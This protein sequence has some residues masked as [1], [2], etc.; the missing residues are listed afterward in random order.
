M[1]PSTRVALGGAVLFLFACAPLRDPWGLAVHRGLP[2]AQA[3]AEPDSLQADVA[4]TPRE[5]G[6]IPFSVRAY[7]RPG[8]A[9]R[10]DVI[11]FPSWIVASYLWVDGRWTWVLHDKK[12]VR[13]GEGNQ[14]EL[15]DSPVRLPN[16]HAALGFLWG[17]MLPGF[18]QRDTL[19]AQGPEGETRW[20]HEGET[21]EARF[22][23]S[24][25]LCREVRSESL[26]LR[27]GS[28]RRQGTRVL[29]G[30]AEI[31]VNGVSLLFL[32]VRDRTEAPKWKKNPFLLVPPASYERR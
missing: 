19:L 31:L 20:I 1:T 6:L 15:E 32:Q 8:R 7:A 29:P 26:T 23:P 21:W 18:A 17:R 2:N 28:Y 9:Y 4:V 11:G 14:F 24:T 16:V 12:Q 5:A 22:D 10:I 30:E 27:Y 25:G 13:A 3:P